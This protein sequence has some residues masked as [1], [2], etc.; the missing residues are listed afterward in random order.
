MDFFKKIKIFFL[1]SLLFFLSSYSSTL[2]DISTDQPTYYPGENIMVTSNNDFTILYNTDTGASLHASQ[3]QSYRMQTYEMLN[4]IGFNLDLGNYSLMSFSDGLYCDQNA[5]NY[6]DCKAANVPDF[7]N[8]AVFSVI[9]PPPNYGYVPP[10]TAPSTVYNGESFSPVCGPGVQYYEIIGLIDPTTCGDFISFGNANGALYELIP[11]DTN[12]NVMSPSVFVKAI[13]DLILP[14]KVKRYEPIVQLI[15]PK[16][17][18]VFGNPISVSYKVTDESTQGYGLGANPVSLS[19]SDRSSDW[20]GDRLLNP[21]NKI[22]IAKDL[23][24]AG[25]YSWSTKNL[26]QG[27]LYRLIIDAVNLAG[28]VG[29]AVSS[30]FS[31]DFIPPTFGVHTDSQVVRNGNI[32]ITIQA[33]EDLSF[34]PQVTVT[35]RNGKPI[36]VAMTGDKDTYQG[37]YTVLPGYDGTAHI[38]VSGTDLA[39]N[40]GREVTSGGTFDI[41]VNPPPKPNIIS[42]LNKTVTGTG[43]VNITGTI[44]EDT[45][46]TLVL[47]GEEVASTTPDAK[48]N[49]AFNNIAL[50]KLK[51]HGTNYISVYSVD[52]LGSESSSADIEIKYNIPPI[53]SISKPMNNDYLSGQISIVAKGSDEN[54][55]I[56]FYTYQIISISNFDSAQAES[57]WMTLADNVTDSTYAWDSTAVDNG[58]YMIRATAFDGTAR[59]TSTP[60]HVYIKNTLPY[61]RFEDG[62]RTVTKNSDVT[63][64]GHAFVANNAAGSSQITNMYYSM[65]GGKSWTKIK[66]GSSSGFEQVFSLTL[67]N[68]DEG[69]YP[70]VFMIKDN[71]GFTGKGSHLLVVDKT[72]PDAP[73]IKTPADNVN[74]INDD[75]EDIQRSGMQISF[76]GTAENGSTVSL[77]SADGTMKTAAL[78]DGTFSFSDVTIQK[79]KQSFDVFATDAA[80]NESKHTTISLTYDNPPIVNFVNPRSFGGLSG[81]ATISW[82]I[83]SP[84]GNPLSNISVSYR[85][86][87]GSFKTLV[88]NAS[89]KGTYDWDTSSLPESNYY[90]LKISASDGIITVSP[91]IDFSIDRTPPSMDSFTLGLSNTKNSFFGFGSASDGLSGVAYVEYSIASKINASSSPWYEAIITKGLMQNQASF[92][93]E[94]PFSF[95]DN[96]YTVSVRA[97]D[98]AGNISSE[99]SKDLLIDK[100]SP[101]I[102][103]F[104]LLEN[105]LNMTP[106]GTGTISLYK[107]SMSDFVASLEGDTKNATLFAGDVPFILKQDNAD[108]L[109]KTRISFDST[110]TVALYITASDHSGNTT[111]KK[112][113]G[114]LSPLEYG[115]VLD[116]IAAPISGAQVFIFKLSDQTQQYDKFIS[117]FGTSST[118][119]SDNDGRYRLALPQGS[120]KLVAMKSGYKTV[121]HDISLERNSFI[122]NSFT[123]QKVTGIMKLVNSVLDFFRYSI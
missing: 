55:D 9:A 46:A 100:T 34:P 56:L 106:D 6:T 120:Y 114:S 60:V 113:I 10:L 77:A 39:L 22:S 45:Y 19:Y 87:G 62:E 5:L 99:M 29:E 51:N 98:G 18:S 2:A 8:E 89:A 4:D 52:K 93:I 35:Q 72:P 24:A 76:L 66:F 58:E 71:G 17:G 81:T 82:N 123:L 102:G 30:F 109:W 110:S 61:V 116:N 65:N 121:E 122:G 12:F 88:S 108:G 36:S 27:I 21:N 63:I 115:S 20:Y 57:K 23:P 73:I 75:D 33:S 69:V 78:P 92:S 50:D 85:Q 14:G 42:N 97:V 86:G 104:F 70:L 74:I 41:G 26:Q 117:S 47:N 3:H 118:I 103:S 67:S 101:R 7:I 54:Q 44:R 80:G 15:S 64:I 91:I 16:N 37:T 1:I 49:F 59:A 119:I 90:Q 111:D 84:D 107:N 43:S 79:G 32:Q 31:L 40:V 96:T 95:S 38:S 112:S 25:N 105:N 48:G 68:L 13:N 11:L 83:M 28:R 94:Y 53:V